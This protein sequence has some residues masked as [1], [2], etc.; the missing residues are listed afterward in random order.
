MKNKKIVISILVLVILII[1][2]IILY[3]YNTNLLNDVL[4]CDKYQCKTTTYK[5]NDI[6]Y[7]FLENYTDY[8]EYK[9]EY[10]KAYPSFSNNIKEYDQEFFVDYKLVVLAPLSCMM[11]NIEYQNT[12]AIISLFSTD[13]DYMDG[14]I[15]IIEVNKTTESIEFI[16]L[17]N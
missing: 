12:Q 14:E 3:T 15:N 5:E 16:N 9:E 11:D 13:C 1:I 7:M 8:L 2:G 6:E 17:D 4:D 10:T